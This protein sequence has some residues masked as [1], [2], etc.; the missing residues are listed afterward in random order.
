VQ[1][2]K[3]ANEGGESMD[4]RV[5]ISVEVDGVRD[6]YPAALTFVH[7]CSAGDNQAFYGDSV[8][9]AMKTALDKALKGTEPYVVYRADQRP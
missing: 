9:T 2:E 1:T 3:I 5:T 7:K 8:Q 4:V 6:H